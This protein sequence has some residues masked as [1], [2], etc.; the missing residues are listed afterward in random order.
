[1]ASSCEKEELPLGDPEDHHQISKDTKYHFNLAVYSGSDDNDPALKVSGAIDFKFLWCFHKD[2]PRKLYDHLLTCIRPNQTEFSPEDRLNVIIRNNR[3]YQHKTMQIDYTTYDMCRDQ[4]SINPR[5][6][7]DVMLLN[8][9]HQADH[10][11]LYARVIGVFHADVCDCAHQKEFRWFEFLLVR[12]YE[13]VKAWECGFKA[14]HLYRV[15]FLDGNDLFAFDFIDP[16]HVLRATHLIP[17][18][19]LGRTRELLGPSIAH[20]PGE[21]DRDFKE[22]LVNM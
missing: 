1:M 19:W 11:Y 4:D 6:R 3:I 8:A 17:R 12:W 20:C 22:Y 5:T 10:A 9:D 21:K 13:V 14:K 7:S 15:C 16:D 2:L 18:F